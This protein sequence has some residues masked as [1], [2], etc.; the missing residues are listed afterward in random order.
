MGDWLA[1]TEALGIGL[2]LSTLITG[3][4]FVLILLLWPRKGGAP[5]PIAA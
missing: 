1:E 3:T 5:V 2:P 4:V